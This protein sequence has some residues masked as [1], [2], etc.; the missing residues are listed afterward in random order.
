[1]LFIEQLTLFLGVV[2]GVDED[3]GEDGPAAARTEVIE[4]TGI[5]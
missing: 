2:A 4:V 5:N 3:V 1:M